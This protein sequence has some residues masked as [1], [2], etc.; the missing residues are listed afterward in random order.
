MSCARSRTKAS[1]WLPAICWRVIVFVIGENRSFVWIVPDLFFQSNPQ[2]KK[3]VY[4]RNQ[5]RWPACLAVPLLAL[6]RRYPRAALGVF[7]CDLALDPV[8]PRIGSDMS[9]RLRSGKAEPLV[10]YCL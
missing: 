3:W 9:T 2:T 7:A 10:R 8:R 5:S 6:E 1:P 4:P